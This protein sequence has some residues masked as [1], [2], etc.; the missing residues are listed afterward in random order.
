MENKN[1]K[2]MFTK[3]KGSE[4]RNS[5]D[6]MNYKKG[7]KACGLS[8]EKPQR[9]ERE[10]DKPSYFMIDMDYLDKYGKGMENMS[11]E[12]LY[13][14]YLEELL[15]LDKEDIMEVF[16]QIMKQEYMDDFTKML[17]DGLSKELCLI[18]AEDELRQK[19]KDYKVIR[20]DDFIDFA[21]NFANNLPLGDIYRLYESRVLK[22]KM[23]EPQRGMGDFGSE[24]RM[25]FSPAGSLKDNMKQG[26]IKDFYT[27][28]E[29][30]DFSLDDF[31][32]NPKLL[33]IVNK[34]IL[35]W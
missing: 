3:Q 31:R 35:R 18:M 33:D 24:E 4:E 25:M 13:E 30:D 14:Y 21:K 6:G 12:D 34:S 27:P 22:E 8:I 10:Q 32:K 15:S 7:K 26:G 5:Y 9:K 23:K 28:D 1:K 2:A 17:Y 20:D 29:V 16:D 11:N 19:G